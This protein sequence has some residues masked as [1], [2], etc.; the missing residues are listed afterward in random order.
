MFIPL[1]DVTLQGL[2]EDWSLSERD[3]DVL[4]FL[5]EEEFQ[6]FT[7]EG[8]TPLRSASRNALPHP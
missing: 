8:Q 6:F 1:L 2:P 7:F 3:I 4:A 5:S